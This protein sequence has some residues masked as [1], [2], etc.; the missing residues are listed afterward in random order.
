M[1]HLARNALPILLLA[2][3]GCYRHVRY[4][5]PEGRRVEVVNFGFDTTIGAL[6]AQTPDGSI[7][8][9]NVDSQALLARRM[10]ELA[11]ALAQEGGR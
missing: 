1:R 9:E 2:S 7:R 11:A 8:L 3:P 10:A 6:E 4:A 5:S